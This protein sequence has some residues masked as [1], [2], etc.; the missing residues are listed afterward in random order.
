MTTNDI[1]IIQ[2]LA[3]TKGGDY[4]LAQSDNIALICFSAEVL[5]FHKVKKE[6]IEQYSL[7]ELAE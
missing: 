4:L 3:K 1:E 5:Q 7:T 6:L 2:V